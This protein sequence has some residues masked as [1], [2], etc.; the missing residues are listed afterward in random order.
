MHCTAAGCKPP[1]LSAPVHILLFSARPLAGA[2]CYRRH[3]RRSSPKSDRPEQHHSSFLNNQ[4]KPEHKQRFNAKKKGKQSPGALSIRWQ[5][6]EL[7]ADHQHGRLKAQ[8]LLLRSPEVLRPTPARDC[9]LCRFHADKATTTLPFSFPSPPRG[10]RT[11]GPDPRAIVFVILLRVWA[12]A[13]HELKDPGQLRNTGR[14]GGH[15]PQ[16][17]GGQP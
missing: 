13:W 4:L 6:R 10:S 3:R 12:A 5:L 1:D 11:G 17:W 8:R 9:D 7:L 15:H 2:H 14:G 16:C